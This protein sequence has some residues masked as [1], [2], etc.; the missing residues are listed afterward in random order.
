MVAIT[1]KWYIIPF[2][3]ENGENILFI[4]GLI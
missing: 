1:L 3:G 4:G 2:E